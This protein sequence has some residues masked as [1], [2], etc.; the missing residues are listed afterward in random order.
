MRASTEQVTDELPKQSSEMNLSK[1][2]SYT[3]SEG[4][5]QQLS[6]NI[7]PNIRAE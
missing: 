2:N 5:A 4:S 1:Q 7:L 6:G 3:G